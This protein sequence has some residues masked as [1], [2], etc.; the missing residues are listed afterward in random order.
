MVRNGRIIAAEAWA[1]HRAYIEDPALDIDPWVRKRTLGGKSDQRRRLHRGARPAQRAAAMFAQWME[2][3]AALLTPTLPISA[4]PLDQVDEAS[5]TAGDISPVSPTIS[6][7]AR[8]RC[9]RD[10]PTRWLAGRGATDRRALRRAGLDPSRTRIPERAPTGT[11][12]GRICRRGS[13]RPSA[14]R[15]LPIAGFH[16]RRAALSLCGDTHLGFV[17]VGKSPGDVQRLAHPRM[18]VPFA[19]RK[20]FGGDPPLALAAAAAT[21]A[22]V[23]I[24]DPCLVQPRAAVRCGACEPQADATNRRFYPQARAWR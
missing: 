17:T 13:Q 15:H 5:D 6:A 1:M 9:R 24:D 19:D 21:R 22:S 14:A 23:P 16:Q 2:G 4:T 18:S 8:C 10:C 12:G 3:R 20:R 7:H 11:C